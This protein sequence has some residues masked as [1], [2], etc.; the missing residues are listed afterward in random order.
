M[1]ET[2]TAAARRRSIL[3]MLGCT[4]LGAAGQILMKLGAHTLGPS[5][6]PLDMLLTPALFF[7]Y[8]LYGMMTV[9]FVFALQHGE[10]SILYPIIALT[11]VWVAGLSVVL[12]GDS[13]GP[14]RVA[15]LLTIILG[16]AILGRNGKR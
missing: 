1:N 16:V 15:G 3:L 12:F 5:K 13:L 10:L 2:T 6:S 7:G 9:L 14:V 11:Y 4:V 8:A